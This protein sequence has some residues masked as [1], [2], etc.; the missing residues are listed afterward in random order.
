M[1]KQCQC[2][3]CF[4]KQLAKIFKAKIYCSR[5]LAEPYCCVQTVNL[6]RCSDMIVSLCL[7]TQNTTAICTVYSTETHI[8][9][10]EVQI[11]TLQRYMILQ[12]GFTQTYFFFTATFKIDNNFTNIAKLHQRIS[13][14]K[15]NRL[16]RS[17][18]SHI[19]F[20][21]LFSFPLFFFLEETPIDKMKIISGY[22]LQ[23][24]AKQFLKTRH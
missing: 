21:C 17:P 19:V 5:F 8:F 22:F 20:M 12:Q 7:N 13:V 9:E 15:V 18:G 10:N 4:Q 2:C 23:W 1:A 11:C 24:W 14:L 16:A 6:H 3:C